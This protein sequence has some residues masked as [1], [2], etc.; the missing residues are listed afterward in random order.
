MRRGHPYLSR[1]NRRHAPPGR[2][3]G[4]EGEAESDPV[5][6]RRFAQTGPFHD[7]ETPHDAPGEVHGAG[8]GPCQRFLVGR[9]SRP[10]EQVAAHH[11]AGHVPANQKAQPAEHLL[12]S[13]SA[14][15]QRLTDALCEPFVIHR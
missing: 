7:D 10:H 15:G 1:A 6:K 3:T 5:R 12:L 4:C 8:E 9:G 11:P 14:G 2:K 13:E